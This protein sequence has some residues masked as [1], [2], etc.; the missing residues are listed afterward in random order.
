MISSLLLT[1]WLWEHDVYAYQSH[2]K[3]QLKEE[4]Q[5]TEEDLHLTK[6]RLLKFIYLHCFLS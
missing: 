3:G 4:A 6:G 2:F 5:Y 1:A